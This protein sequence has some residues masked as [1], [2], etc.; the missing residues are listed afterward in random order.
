MRAYSDRRKTQQWAKSGPPLGVAFGSPS[1]SVASLA[2]ATSPRCATLLA[3]MLPKAITAMQ[4][5]VIWL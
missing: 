4:P 3:E 2:R 1:D 5:N